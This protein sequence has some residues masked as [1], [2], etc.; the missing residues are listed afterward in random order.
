[1]ERLI[2][3]MDEVLAFKPSAAK[4]SSTDLE[5]ICR[6]VTADIEGQAGKRLFWGSRTVDVRPTG[7]YLATLPDPPL[8]SITSVTYFSGETDDTGEVLDL[9]DFRIENAETG[10]VWA[11]SQWVS[12]SLSGREVSD[13]DRQLAG[14]FPG[15]YASETVPCYWRV[16][17]VSG[18]EPAPKYKLLAKEWAALRIDRLSRIGVMIES[19]GRGQSRS[20]DF[21]KEEKRIMR[22]VRRA[23][24]RFLL[25]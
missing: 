11:S 4:L 10:E 5:E 14:A 2:V 22:D 23:A 12:M 7:K 17:Y 19:Y 15:E 6:A 24:G 18:N 8:R 1:V 21:E 3:T 20:Y 13:Q 25:R 16:V 9:D